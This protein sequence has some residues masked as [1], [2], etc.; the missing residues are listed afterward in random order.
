MFILPYCFGVQVPLEPQL[1]IVTLIQEGVIGLETD[2]Q[3][4]WI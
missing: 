2:L 4:L 1:G 3:L